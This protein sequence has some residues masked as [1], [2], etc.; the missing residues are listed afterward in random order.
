M[1]FDVLALGLL[2]GGYLVGR[3]TVSSRIEFLLLPLA[4]QPPRAVDD[5]LP[6]A[7]ALDRYVGDGLAALDAYVAA[8]GR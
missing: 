6:S 5:P 1:L 3:R 7:R 8:Q 2:V 4:D